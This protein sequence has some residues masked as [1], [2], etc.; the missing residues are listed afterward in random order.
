MSGRVNL[1][2][3]SVS[4]PEYS[5]ILY[6]NSPGTAIKQKR[7]RRNNF[8]V[9][10]AP[11][12]ATKRFSMQVK[13]HSHANSTLKT[14]Q[15]PALTET[16]TSGI[17]DPRGGLGTSHLVKRDQPARLS[18]ASSSESRNS[19]RSGFPSR[20]SIFMSWKTNSGSS[21]WSKLSS[22]LT[23][24]QKIS[25]QKSRAQKRFKRNL[26]RKLKLAFHPKSQRLLADRSS[27][28]RSLSRNL[29]LN[30]LVSKFV[31]AG[32]RCAAIESHCP[33]DVLKAASQWNAK[34]R[35]A[36]RERKNAKKR[37]KGESLAVNCR[38]ESR[39]ISFILRLEGSA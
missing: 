23:L 13:Y 8:G 3:Q 33:V 14:L 20:S 25:R 2:K 1:I 35:K 6:F 30:S 29:K 37:L 4:L 7:Q 32:L 15:E 12:P 22:S 36:Y 28:L 17:L 11:R 26:R 38:S 5:P 16:T 27:K 10:A 21:M 19:M 34:Q 18:N 24:K 39:S 31:C 9:A